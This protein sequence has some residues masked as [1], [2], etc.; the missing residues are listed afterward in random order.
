MFVY[1]G[2]L[3]GVREQ[4]VETTDIAL[5]HEAGTAGTKLALG[6]TG[7][8]TEVVSTASGIGLVALRRFAKT[9]RCRPVGLQLGHF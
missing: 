4:L 8:V 7:F 2:G 6:F 9:L 3:L 5:M 1:L